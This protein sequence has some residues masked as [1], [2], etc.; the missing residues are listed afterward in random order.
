MTLSQ[1]MP[2]LPS[3]LL[4]KGIRS[5]Y[6]LYFSAATK[7]IRFCKHSRPLEGY[8]ILQEITCFILIIEV[9]K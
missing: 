4:N 8:F 6:F 7:V 5:F 3:S 9:L 2:L 1:G